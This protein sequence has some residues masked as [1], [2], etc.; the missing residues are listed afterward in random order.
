MADNAEVVTEEIIKISEK[1]LHTQDGK[2]YEVDMIVCATGFNTS[3][4][5]NFDL[6]GILPVFL[7]PI[8]FS[9]RL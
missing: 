1:G 9:R 7:I 4:C 5:P 2:I 8:S 6:I 3:F